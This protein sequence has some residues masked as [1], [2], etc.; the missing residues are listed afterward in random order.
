ML[1]RSSP[2]AS[3]ESDIMPEERHQ[4]RRDRQLVGLIV[5]RQSRE[6]ADRRLLGLD[7]ADA[8]QR[9]QRRDGASVD[10]ACELER[11]A[12]DMQQMA[13]AVDSKAMLS[14]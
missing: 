9:D 14:T 4:P 7:G 5:R 8:E 6:R 1:G 12:R 10:D 3:K 13:L 2:A 11:V